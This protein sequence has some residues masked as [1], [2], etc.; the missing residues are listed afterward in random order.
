[1]NEQEE[2]EF[3]AAADAFLSKHENLAEPSGEK[4]HFLIFKKTWKLFG[5][6]SFSIIRTV[7]EEE[8]SDTI[9]QKVLDKINAELNQKFAQPPRNQ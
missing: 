2:K 3:E 6:I 9:S 7:N 8:F 1:M 4:S 5:F